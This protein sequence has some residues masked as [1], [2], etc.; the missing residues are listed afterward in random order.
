MIISPIGFLLKADFVAKSGS[1]VEFDKLLRVSVLVLFKL[2]NPLSAFDLD[3]EIVNR[4]R[5]FYRSAFRGFASNKVGFKL[6]GIFILPCLLILHKCFFPDL[7][8]F[9]LWIEKKNCL[10]LLFMGCRCCNY[11]VSKQYFFV[12]LMR[13]GNYFGDQ[14]NHL[15]LP[16]D[17]LL[18]F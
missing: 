10:H 14:I 18:N 11:F 12:F 1:K 4:P 7:I 9:L 6:I 16:N 2:L 5:N 3:L 8:A 13:R 17:D 15:T